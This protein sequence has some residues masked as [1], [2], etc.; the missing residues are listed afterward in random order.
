[1]IAVIDDH[2]AA[3]GV[4]PIGRVL[5]IGIVKLAVSWVA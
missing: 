2:R 5:P 3:H 4:E 1:M